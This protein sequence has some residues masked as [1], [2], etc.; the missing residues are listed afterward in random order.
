MPNTTWPEGLIARYLTV[1]GAHVDLIHVTH[2]GDSETYSTDAACSGC[3]TAKS[4]CHWVGSG[5]WDDYKEERAPEAADVQA[6]AWAQ[7]H[8]ETCRAIP[9]PTV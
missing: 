4:V 7:S 3:P 9:R 5:S 2:P 1:G 6:R 8:A